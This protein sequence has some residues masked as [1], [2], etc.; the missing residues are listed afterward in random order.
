MVWF[1]VR[2]W[3]RVRVRFRVR[4]RVRVRVECLKDTRGRCV[5]GR[6]EMAER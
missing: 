3:V 5:V 1:W 2:F 4:V 6:R